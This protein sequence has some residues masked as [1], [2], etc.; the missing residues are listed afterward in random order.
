M[1]TQH[2]CF[3]CE[4]TLNTWDIGSFLSAFCNK[5]CCD[6]STGIYL[7]CRHHRP[8]E[9]L[10]P[11]G[12]MQI[13]HLHIP[14]RLLEQASRKSQ[15][16]QRELDGGT[17]SSFAIREVQAGQMPRS[18]Y[19]TLHFTV[20][21]TLVD[22][23]FSSGECFFPLDCPVPML[24]LHIDY[25]TLQWLLLEQYF[26]NI[27]AVTLTPG[28]QKWLRCKQSRSWEGIQFGQLTE[29]DQRDNHTI[30]HHAHQCS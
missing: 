3:C 15:S 9:I 30:W 10:L 19:C 14:M 5:C 23:F 18:T 1:S 21:A 29:R 17:A 12:V 7:V 2:S 22:C 24:E 28:S 27:R 20:A 11:I 4:I 25:I 16:K 6:C 8:Y 26:H 13:K